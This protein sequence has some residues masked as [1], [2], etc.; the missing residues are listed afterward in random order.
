MAVAVTMPQMGESMV[1]GTVARWLKAPGET[2]AKFEALVEINTDKIDTEIPAP[3]AGTL[4]EVVV[5][6]GQTVRAGTVLGYIGAQGEHP[7]QAEATPALPASAPS[8]A[9]STRSSTPS[10]ISSS[11]HSPVS[12]IEQAATVS[13]QQSRPSSIV[14]SGEASQE[15]GWGC[16]VYP[17]SNA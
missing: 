8:I 5:D 13:S 12:S 3:A 4:I 7:V 14:T 10:S 1:E 11:A 9:S 15:R 6:A 2:V 17:C 16:R